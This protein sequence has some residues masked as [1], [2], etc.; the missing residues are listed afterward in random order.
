MKRKRIFSSPGTKTQKRP[1]NEVIDSADKRATQE[2]P[3]TS[4]P[5]GHTITNLLA[6]TF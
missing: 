1:L 5:I 4:P 3:L 2:V 6:W